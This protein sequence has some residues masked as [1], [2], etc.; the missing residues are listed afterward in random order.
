M[1]PCQ[2]R[3]HRHGHQALSHLGR[4][5]QPSLRGTDAP[6][7]LP[8]T[9]NLPGIDSQHGTC[10]NSFSPCPSRPRAHARVTP[11]RH[12]G[13]RRT[14]GA[15]SGP[16]APPA[17]EA[18][19]K[20]PDDLFRTSGEPGASRTV[21][22]RTTTPDPSPSQRCTAGRNCGVATE[23]RATAAPAIRSDAGEL[24]RPRPLVSGSCAARIRSRPTAARS[25]SPGSEA[26]IGPSRSTTRGAGRMESGTESPGPPPSSLCEFPERWADAGRSRSQLR[27]V[28][29]PVIGTV[30]PGNC[31]RFRA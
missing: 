29:G 28:G 9:R 11:G 4:G 5:R 25:P 23:P 13:N 24:P 17:N 16:L 31:R 3:Y 12:V 7:L 1:T 18:A 26:C 6:T 10:A 2:W 15:G 27:H 20:V 19:A 21:S 8:K 30:P 14:C 22:S